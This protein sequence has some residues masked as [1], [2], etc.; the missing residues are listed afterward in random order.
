MHFHVTESKIGD[1]THDVGGD[2]AL[3]Y[4]TRRPTFDTT[5]GA[6]D[7]VMAAAFEYWGTPAEIHVE[8]S[9]AV[10][11]SLGKQSSKDGAVATWDVSDDEGATWALRACECADGTLAQLFAGRG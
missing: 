1:V 4:P 6:V 9:L 7:A 2:L 5:A 8:V 3:P 11:L 10:E